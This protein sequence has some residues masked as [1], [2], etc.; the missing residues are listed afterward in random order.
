MKRTIISVVIYLLVLI[1]FALYGPDFFYKHTWEP[2][3]LKTID[4]KLNNCD[5]EDK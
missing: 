4:I 5:C 2:R 1:I 3:V